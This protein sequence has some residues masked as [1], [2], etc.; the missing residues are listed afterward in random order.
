[1]KRA[2]IFL[3]VIM[4]ASGC[5]STGSQDAEPEE[6]P[7]ENIS[8]NTTEHKVYYTADGFEPESIT[9]E[10]GD[11]VT[12]VNNV[13]SEMWVGSD[14][15][16]SHTQYDGTSVVR[17]CSGGES[18]TFDQCSTGEEYSFTFTKTGEWGYHNH[19]S[20]FDTGTVVVE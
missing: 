15:H 7:V 6:M 12:W 18:D 13:S 20:P 8:Q 10:Q 11:T 17:H 19:R 14:N 5:S 9:I 4:I 16:P 3:T 1:M 2:L